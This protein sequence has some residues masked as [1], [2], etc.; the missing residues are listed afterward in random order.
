MWDAQLD[1]LTERFQVV[2]YDTRGHG[3][4]PVPAGPY[5]ID[6]L[7][8]DV[9]ALLDRLGIASA[10]LI[11]LSLGGMT[12][13]RLAARDPDRVDR[14]GL[15]CTAARLASTQS[16]LARAQ[17]VRAHSAS[18]VAESVV[19]RWFTPAYLDA[20]PEVRATHEQMVCSTSD[21]GYAACCEAIAEMDL[22]Q[23]LSAIAA[24]TLAMAA[25]DD[26]ATP[27]Q[28]LE[29]IVGQIPRS[30]LVLIEDAA[31]LANVQQP[32][33]VTAALLAHLEH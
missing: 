21:E 1:A 4:S 26:P 17:T 18:A 30:R 11:G 9:V 8:D 2:R 5:S 7:A 16:W 14:I 25:A 15:L 28:L 20:H 13:M 6:D 10:H 27:P 3:Q 29:D 33:V 24:P 22:R 32:T 23:D 12:V 19:S 31:H